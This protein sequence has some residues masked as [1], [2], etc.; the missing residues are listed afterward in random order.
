MELYAHLQCS[1]CKV[2]TSTGN[3][4]WLKSHKDIC[5]QAVIHVIPERQDINRVVGHSLPP[6]HPP[7]FFPPNKTSKSTISFCIQ[8]L[9]FNNTLL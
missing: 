2:N 9:D 1:G 3:A 8:L 5:S 7:F 6:S 4:F